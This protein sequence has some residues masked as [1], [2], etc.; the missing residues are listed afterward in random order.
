MDVNPAAI[1]RNG[2]QDFISLRATGLI[3]A[4]YSLCIVAFIL[5]TPDMTYEIWKG[6]FSGLGMKIFTLLA[7][8]CVSIHARIGMWQV[9]TDYIKN[10]RVRA[11]L[12]FV[13]SVLSF[14]YVAAGLFVLWGA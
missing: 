10:A 8:C 14:V 6:T 1:K 3:L 2:I 13:V 5:T 11:V 4:A 7:L 9:A 12:A